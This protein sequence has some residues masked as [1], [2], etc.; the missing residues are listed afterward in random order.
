[1]GPVR[2][3]VA[4]LLRYGTLPI[5]FVLVFGSLIQL[6]PGVHWQIPLWLSTPAGLVGAL[7]MFGGVIAFSAGLLWRSRGRMLRGVEFRLDQSTPMVRLD[8]RTRTRYRPLSQLSAVEVWCTVEFVDMYDNDRDKDISV[9]LRLEFRHP[10]NAYCL[11][12]VFLTRAG[13]DRTTVATL[14]RRALAGTD[15]HVVERSGH[16]RAARRR[17]R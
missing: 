5:S 2:G 9:W 14:L 10:S 16:A 15:V 12:P 4:V 6:I 11:P 17:R 7:L 1:M 13:V 8:L 3:R